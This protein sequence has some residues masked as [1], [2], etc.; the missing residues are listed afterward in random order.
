MQ[1]SS[2][3]RV[4]AVLVLALFTLIGASAAAD[5]FQIP[6]DSDG[7]PAWSIKQWTDFP[8][9]IELSDHAALQNLLAQVPIASFDRSQV[10][11]EFAGGRIARLVFTPRVTDAEFVRLQLAGYRP[12]KV[13]DLERENREESERTWRAMAA[14]KAEALYTYPLN[15]VPTNDQIGTMLQELATAY[16]NLARYYTWGTS[17]QGRT[18]HAI[19]ISDNV[20]AVEAEP[21]VRYSS[22]MHGDEITGLVLCMNLAQYLLDVY[23]QPGYED[24]TDLVDNFE[25]HLIPSYNPDGTYLHQRNNANN[26]DLNRNFPLPAGTHPILQLENRLFMDHAAANHFVISINYHGGALVMNYPW[27]YTYTLAPDT[28]AIIKLS[29]EYS[30]RNLPM[31]NGAFPQGITNGAAWYVITGSLQDWSYDQTDCIDVTCE[32]ST[33]KWPSGSALPGFW[34]DNRDAMVAY[35]RS[36]RAGVTG[37]VTNAVTGEPVAAT[38]TV[39]GNTKPVHTN[40]ANGDYY[41]LLDDGTFQLTVTATGYV[42]QTISNIVNVWGVEHV[43]DVQLE[44]V[45][46]GVVFGTVTNQQG[47]PL[48]A[49]IQAA[50][51][52]GG[53]VV[54]SVNAL[55]SE[56]GVYTLDV[57][58]GSYTITASAVDYF[59]GSQQVEVS[60]SPQELDF[61]LGGAVVSYP[62]SEDFETSSGVFGSVWVLFSPGYNSDQC[63]K[64]SAGNYPHN[65][66]LL[67]TMTSGISFAEVSDPVVSFQARWAIE[68]TWDAVFFEISTNGGTQWTAL[69]VPG[70]TRLASGQGAQVPAGTPCFDG[71]QSSWVSCS[72][73]LAAYVGQPDVRFRFRLAS[74]GSNAGAGFYLD[75]FVVQVL[76]A[77]GSVPVDSVPPLLAGV[78][79]YPNPF[80][81]RTTIHFANPQAGAVKIVVY[82]VQGRLV[83]SLLQDD[84]PRGEHTV[85]WDGLNEAGEP[86]GSGVYVARMETRSGTAGAKLTLVR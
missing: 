51:S 58:Y 9:R 45:P 12:E 44:P 39:T 7:L 20:D 3:L 85:E 74:D 38:I 30:T 52:P 35:A 66:T 26:V 1:R 54:A 64:S 18:L 13:R 22:S 42:A 34:N 27:D 61:V 32:V 60:A 55:A 43:V 83:R 23:G 29:L 37:R 6:L 62:V 15:Y 86:A 84:L 4:S 16:P 78:T 72:V 81:P 49:V 57:Y 73:D 31:Y 50:T 70:R 33:T 11:P 76:T 25:L 63:L 10:R 41:K 56:G 2:Q 21:Q 65:A 82:D 68:T 17:V 24:E 53:E 14:G 8:V 36:A 19:V 75:D 59:P 79:A 46:T 47:Q 48:D 40:P 5:D 67:A 28:D 69:A 71:T 80:N 77:G